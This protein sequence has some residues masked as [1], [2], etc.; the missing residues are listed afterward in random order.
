MGK[1]F[2]HRGY[3]SGKVTFA[4]EFNKVKK[5]RMYSRQYDNRQYS[6]TQS[7]D[8]VNNMFGGGRRLK[9]KKPSSESF[10]SS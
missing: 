2:E 9:D 3:S 5:N 1:P 8:I 4:A 7:D 6:P 10:V